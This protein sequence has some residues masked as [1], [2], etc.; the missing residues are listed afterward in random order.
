MARS[1]IGPLA[2]EAPLGGPRSSLY[3][4]VHVRQRVQVAVRIF[5]L[6]LGMTPEASK[7]FNQQLELLKTIRSP[8]LVRCFGGGIDAKDAYVVYEMID[9]ESLEQALQR[10][11]RLAWES[12]LEMGLQLCQALQTIHDRGII[13]GRIRPDKILLC[14]GG[15]TYK[16]NDLRFQFATQPLPSLAHLATMPPESFADRATPNVAWDLYS[17]GATMYWGLTGEPPF[18]GESAS[19]VRHA[20]LETPLQGVATKVFDCPVWLCAIVEQMLQRDPLRRPYSAAAAALAFQEAQRR[21][22]QG[23]GVVEY[24]VSGFSPLQLNTDRAEAERVLGIKKKR[25]RESDSEEENESASMSIWERPS[26]LVASLIA[27]LGLIAYLVWPLNESQMRFRA[28]TMLQSDNSILWNDARDKYLQPMLE[29]FPD[30]QHAQWAQEQ[31]DKVAMHNAEERMRRNLRVGRDP[32]SEGERKY[33][34]ALRFERFGDRVTALDKYRGIV[35]LLTNEPKE[36]PF[37]N[38]AKRQ[39]AILESNPPSVEEL[40]KFLQDKLAEADQLYS[41][42]DVLG[43]RKTWEGIVSLYNGNQEMISFV[44]KSQSRLEGNK[45]DPPRNEP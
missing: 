36:Q 7:E 33:A 45:N 1:R 5:P 35:K 25:K 27:I 38:L 41:D 34:E 8:H 17:L 31:L 40:K 19:G 22:S 20:I 43:A 44:E 15:E 42:G 11:Q 37:V 29:R 24:A 32:S 28:E 9:G 18:S 2:L 39:I 21:A 16:L 6:S 10:R 23:I 14:N 3:R 30:G 12:V 13:H 26:V 4:A